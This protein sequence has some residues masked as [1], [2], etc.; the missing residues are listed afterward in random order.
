M[1]GF[2]D[3]A[4]AVGK[5]VMKYGPQLLQR[6]GSGYYAGRTGDV[7]GAAMM[8]QQAHMSRQHQA[9]TAELAQL[10]DL[11]ADT[12]PE[13]GKIFSKYGFQD[14][15]LEVVNM[16]QRGE[17]MQFR[18]NA[19]SQTASQTQSLAERR[20][21]GAEETRALAQTKYESDQ[22]WKQR[23]FAQK[24]RELEA[25]GGVERKDTSA[26]RRLWRPQLDKYR[27]AERAYRTV[28]RSLNTPMGALALIN[29]F[30][31]TIDPGSVVRTE[32]GKLIMTGAGLPQ[33]FL[34][35]IWEITGGGKIGPEH[36]QM[37]RDQAE[38]YIMGTRAAHN[39][40]IN[41]IRDQYD[42]EGWQVNPLGD[43][44][45]AKPMGEGWD[46]ETGDWIGDP[47]KFDMTSGVEPATSGVQGPLKG[48]AKII[49][50][51]WDD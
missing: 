8:N 24:E 14:K 34:N 23:E 2:G 44:W 5:G 3:F 12:L 30:A 41:K 15:F 29:A 1:M 31:K 25:E 18:R 47:S 21:E 17:D 26:A 16:V 49:G 37:I 33:T 11:S 46:E 43:A 42:D 51:E 36:R 28:E 27:E 6:A 45:S 50:V 22:D 38:A 13:V 20:F 32:E 35:K 10:G 40:F 39:Q 48:T 19:T 7:P 9:M 4:S